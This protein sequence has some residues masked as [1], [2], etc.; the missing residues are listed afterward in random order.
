MSVDESKKFFYH[1]VQIGL[2]II[3]KT[4]TTIKDGKNGFMAFSCFRFHYNLFDLL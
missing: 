4:V 3:S 2:A 1:L